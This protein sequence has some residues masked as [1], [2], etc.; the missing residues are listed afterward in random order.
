MIKNELSTLH[1]G[2]HVADESTVAKARDTITF[3]SVDSDCSLINLQ[4]TRLTRPVPDMTTHLQTP[5]E[6]KV[7]PRTRPLPGP[8]G[9]PEQGLWNSEVILPR[10]LSAVSFHKLTRCFGGR[11][12]VDGATLSGVQRT[13]PS[14]CYMPRTTQGTF[15]SSRVGYARDN[16]LGHLT[17]WLLPETAYR[18][19]SGKRHELER[20]NG[21]SDPQ[22]KQDWGAVPRL[23]PRAR[24]HPSVLE[25]RSGIEDADPQI[26]KT[27]L[28]KATSMLANSLRTSSNFPTT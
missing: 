7:E 27:W 1:Q 20:P 4:T 6:L 2:D 28:F 22:R 13:L 24:L 23:Q 18:E 21:R 26:V 3:K 9:D 25:S 10:C 12:C 14:P 15:R 8:V 11:I 19:I 17:A 5:M 16:S